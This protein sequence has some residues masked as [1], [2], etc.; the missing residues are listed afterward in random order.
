MNEIQTVNF[1]KHSGV[2][3]IQTRKFIYMETKEKKHSR[4]HIF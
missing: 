4:H 3:V 1:R 2:G